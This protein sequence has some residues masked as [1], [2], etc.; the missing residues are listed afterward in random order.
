MG[1]DVAGSSVLVLW[2]VERGMLCAICLGD[3]GLEIKAV[4]VQR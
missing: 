4:C 2:L 3:A 1:C